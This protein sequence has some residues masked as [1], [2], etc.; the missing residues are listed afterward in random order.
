VFGMA[1]Y[2]SLVTFWPYN[3]S[4][5]LNHYQF[6]DTAGGGWLAYRNSLT[7]ATLDRT[8]RQRS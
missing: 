3:L 2:S 6:N 1:V 7:M 5:S 4:L 8:D